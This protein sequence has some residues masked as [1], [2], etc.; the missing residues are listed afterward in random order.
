M[1]SYSLHTQ[2]CPR[3]GVCGEYLQLIGKQ[4]VAG[5]TFAGSREP[6]FASSVAHQHTPAHWLAV[7]MCP[8]LFRP[9]AALLSQLKIM[10]IQGIFDQGCPG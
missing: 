6:L 3:H 9:L 5:V 1:V 4:L 8:A 10:P 2:G 7:P